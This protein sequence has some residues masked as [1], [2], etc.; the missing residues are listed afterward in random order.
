M[1]P[2]QYVQDMFGLAPEE[3]LIEDF[4]CFHD[5][6]LVQPAHIY[7]TKQYLCYHIHGLKGRELVIPWAHICDVKKKNTAKVIPNAVLLVLQDHSEIFFSFIDRNQCYKALHMAWKGKEHSSAC[8]HEHHHTTYSDLHEEHP[9]FKKVKEP[10]NTL[11]DLKSSLPDIK[12]DSIQPITNIKVEDAYEVKRELG[13]GAF[14]IVKLAI[15]KKSKEQRAIKMI[16]KDAIKEKKEML[17]R[18]VDILKRIQHPNIIAVVEIYETPRY[19]NLVMELATGGELFDSIV[20]RGK[21]TEKDAA[22]IIQQVASACKYLHS[23]GIVHRDLKPENLLLE[24]KNPDCRIKIADFGLSKIMEAQSIL[25]TACGTPGYVAPEVLIGEGYN[26]EVDVWSIGV[27]MYILLCGFPPFYADNNSKLFEKIMSGAYSFPSPYWDKISA[28]AKDLIKCMLV[29]DPKKRY[30]SSQVMDHPWIK[31]L[32]GVPEELLGDAQM[33]LKKTQSEETKVTVL[34]AV[35]VARM[36]AAKG[37][38]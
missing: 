34:A 32:V 8:L 13:S 27:I 35:P 10:I 24:N 7:L 33:N 20:S 30:T 21:Y 37:Y 6:S 26:Q 29:V 1:K 9:N 18:E 31:E 4:S 12:D 15:H 23:I 22:R 17:E 25:Q 2:E 19:L 11:S 5:S 16:D 3:K 14:S 28:S 36:Y 38:D